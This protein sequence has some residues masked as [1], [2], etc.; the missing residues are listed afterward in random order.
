MSNS[1]SET[2][3]RGWEEWCGARKVEA[4]VWRKELSTSH[5]KGQRKRKVECGSER[6]DES[7]YSAWKSSIGHA[8]RRPG[9]KGS[10][11]RPP[12]GP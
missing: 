9:P 3:Y 4:E 11:K 8:A 12:V 6:P 7:G 5:P 1:E 10:P 2:E